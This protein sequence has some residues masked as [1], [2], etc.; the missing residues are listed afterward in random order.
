MTSEFNVERT[1][2]DLDTFQQILGAMDGYHVLPWLKTSGDDDGT[3]I[4]VEPWELPGMPPVSVDS[5]RY[6]AG[7]AIDRGFVECWSPDPQNTA[8]TRH[9][10]EVAHDQIT[11]M[12]NKASRPPSHGQDPNVSSELRPARLTYAGKEFVDNLNNPSVRAQAV[13]AHQKMG[14]TSDDAGSG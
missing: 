3:T 11:R 13:E 2:F 10:S 1:E 4:D 7:F 12:L 5:W 8:T 14:T 9:L 6:H